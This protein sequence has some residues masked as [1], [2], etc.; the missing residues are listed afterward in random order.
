MG[1]II[2]VGVVRGAS[3]DVLSHITSDIVELAVFNLE[4]GRVL[5]ERHIG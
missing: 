4:V 1:D 3:R 2:R 5:E